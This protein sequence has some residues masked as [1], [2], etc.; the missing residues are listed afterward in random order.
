MISDSK[1]YVKLLCRS[2]LAHHRVFM[3]LLL[4]TDCFY[5]AHPGMSSYGVKFSIKHHSRTRSRVFELLVSTARVYKSN[6]II[7]GC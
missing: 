4:V 3:L 5:S 6:R 1:L 2:K 7:V